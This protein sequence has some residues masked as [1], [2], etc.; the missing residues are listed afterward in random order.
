M[1]AA[2]DDTLAQLGHLN[3]MEFSRQM[4]RAAGRDGTIY[5]NDGM[6]FYAGHS[7]FPLPYNG[8]WRIDETVPGA[9]VLAAS[10]EWFAA[11]S[12]GY[13]V[14]VRDDC[15][16]DDDLRAAAEAAGLF[17][18]VNQP[19]MICR[20]RVED[21]ALPDGARLQWVAEQQTFDDF[22]AV[23]D[24]AY[25]TLG[26]PER[27]I[28]DGGLQLDPFTAPNVFSVVAYAHDVPVAAAQT[29]LS[30]TVAGVYWVGTVPEARGTG[31]GDAVARAVTNRAFD[32]GARANSLQASHMGEKIYARMGYETFYR[33]TDFIRMAPS[34]ARRNR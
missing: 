17:A 3:Y 20:A 5:E 15:R 12:H 7:S 6:L 25:Q 34:E 8:V 13:S 29:V 32:E 14:A 21:R 2:D 11:R 10:E 31:L 22:L 23:N 1:P 33:Y 26:L 16:A 30:H 18:A 24:T 28:L 9:D 19:E 27:V 4:A